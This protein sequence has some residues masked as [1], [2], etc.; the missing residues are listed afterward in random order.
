MARD[1][2]KMGYGLN[3]DNLKEAEKPKPKTLFRN[4][5]YLISSS[6]ELFEPVRYCLL[7]EKGTKLG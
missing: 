3:G 5:T 4:T 7:K 1:V 6:K 2:T